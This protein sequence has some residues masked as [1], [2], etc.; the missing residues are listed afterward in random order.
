MKIRSREVLQ[1]YL[2]GDWRQLRKLGLDKA[3]VK[4]LKRKKAKA[5]RLKSSDIFPSPEAN[6][7]AALWPH[8]PTESTP[9]D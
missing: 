6:I 5:L 2:D 7:G 3:E 4:R 8:L 9:S 1:A